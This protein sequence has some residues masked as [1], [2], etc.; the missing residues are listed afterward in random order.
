V[1]RLG[2]HSATLS[3]TLPL[4]LLGACAST[5]QVPT[6]DQRRLARLAESYAQQLH[7]V[8]ILA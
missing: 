5:A 2:L 8:G 3:K 7:A 6:A 4:F 1:R